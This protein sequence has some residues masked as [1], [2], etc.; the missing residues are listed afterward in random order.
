MNAGSTA[1]ESESGRTDLRLTALEARLDAILP[2][3]AT[4]A[5]LANLRTEFREGLANLRAEFKEDM[6]KLRAEFKDEFAAL[7]ADMAKLRD[8]QHTASEKL[9]KWVVSTMVALVIACLGTMLAIM[10][11][12]V[13]LSR[14]VPAQSAR[15]AAPAAANYVV[16]PTRIELVSHA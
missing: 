15:P 14:S 11:M 3:L 9:L 7:R 16:P 12:A 13:T 8:E 4:K 2:T 6:A 1:P 5:D 10:N